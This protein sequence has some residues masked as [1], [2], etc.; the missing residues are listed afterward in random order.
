MKLFIYTITEEDGSPWA[1]IHLGAPCPQE[2]MESLALTGATA[3]LSVHEVPDDGSHVM[4]ITPDGYELRATET[5]TSSE[6]YSG[7]YTA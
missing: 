5:S 7:S 6:G 1:A 2:L 4:L 3:E